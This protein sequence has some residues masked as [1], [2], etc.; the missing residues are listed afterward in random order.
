LP[1]AVAAALGVELHGGIAEVEAIAAAL[2]DRRLLLVLDNCEHLANAAAAFGRVL[3]DR[4]PGLSILATSQEPLRLAGEQRYAVKPLDLPPPEMTADETGSAGRIAG[5]SATALFIARAY[6]ADA[7]FALGDDNAGLVAAIVRGLDGIPL[8]LEL[9]ASLV[10]SLGLEGLRE[11]V[12]E[13][14][15]LLTCDGR[16]AA[17]RHR[18][19]LDTVER[20][21]NLLGGADRCSFRRLGIFR[22]SFTAAAAL[23]VIRPEAADPAEARDSFRR[24]IDK[25]LVTVEAGKTRRYRLL[26]MLQV[27][28]AKL[29]KTAGESESVA[30]IHARYFAEL[31]DRAGEEWETMAD[32]E[33]RRIYAP[34]FDNV[35]AAMDWALADPARAPIAIALSGAARLWSMLSLLPEG[36]RQAER[37]LPL[38]TEATPPAAAARALRRIGML[39][40][41]SD[42]QRA[43]ALFERSAALYRQLDDRLSLG[44]VLGLAGGDCA[45]LGRHAE[46]KLALDE[47]RDLLAGSE[48]RKSLITV[49]NELG[50]L[51]LATNEPDEAR[52][53]YAAALDLARDL[54]DAVREA[55]VLFNQ[56][57]LEF[58]LGAIDPAIGYARESVNRLRSAD[59]LSRC[60]LPLS[61]LAAYETIKGDHAEARAHATE[62]L[63]LLGPEGGYNLRV[64]LQLWALIACREQRYPVAAQ[65]KG[66]IDAWYARTGE[67]RQRLGQQIYDLLSGILADNLAPDRIRALAAEGARWSEARALEITLHHIVSPEDSAP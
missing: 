11:W 57:E 17:G 13:G 31:F 60:G 46:A 38:I 2:R 34:E 58:S 37:L 44:S 18:T 1:S 22:G 35:R 49:M 28:A 24:L 4:V 51:A 9:A 21:Y 36:R 23:A 54:D 15:A 50:S 27:Y 25:S 32:P 39:W 52:Q 66:C 14:A 48:R 42:R 47:A 30:E 3:L 61:N 20:S 62:A 63:S 33:W 10:P 40:R 8:Q 67:T 45:Y 5:C 55:I 7:D 26:Q 12:E 43:L 65:L 64:C 59:L 29:L 41:G 16:D 19:L 6:A 53:H 56:G